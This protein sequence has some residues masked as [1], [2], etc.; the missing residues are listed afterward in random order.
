MPVRELLWKVVLKFPDLLRLIVVSHSS[1]LHLGIQSH[2]QLTRL[3]HVSSTHSL[4]HIYSNHYLLDIRLRSLSY[5]SKKEAM[6]LFSLR[7]HSIWEPPSPLEHFL[8]SPLKFL[9]R[10]LY[11]FILFL[12]GP[13]YRPPPYRTPIRV[14][15]ISDTHCKKRAIPNGDLLI[16]AGDLSNAGTVTEIQEQID[17]LKSLPHSQK[18]VIAGNHDSF[19]DP[20]SRKQEDQ[21]K[22]TDKV[23]D[24]GDIHYLERSSVTLAFPEHGHR[25]L[26]VYGAPQI[27]LFGGSSFAFQYPRDW[28]TWSNTI[29]LETDILVTHTPPKYHLDLPVAL[30]CKILG[31]NIWKV[32]PILHVFGHVHSGYGRE[33]AFWD[34]T[35]QIYERICARKNAGVMADVLDLLAWVD[36][37]RL[38]VSG[39]KGVLWSRIWG[40]GSTGTLLVNASL[41]YRSTG[42]L[43]NPPQVVEI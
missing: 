40:G 36:V 43:R 1:H 19:F 6:L 32:R 13:A 31:Q 4:I 24:W 37:G 34:E 26:H 20:K 3:H 16:H 41:S 28:D 23:L 39:V 10:Y 27:P 9:I 11:A 12:R 5:C 18:I 15:C 33:S 8:L 42:E 2:S 14:I 29:P 35:Q 17:W 25:R 21:D 30:G 38:A 22:D 7:P